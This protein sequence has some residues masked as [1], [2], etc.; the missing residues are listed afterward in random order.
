MRLSP[1]KNSLF[2]YSFD[3]VQQSYKKGT[4]FVIN[5]NQKFRGK[6]LSDEP[7]AS[8]FRADPSAITFTKQE[9]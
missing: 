5:F 3:I 6:P 9:S 7:A 8:I 4:A 1:S 2:T